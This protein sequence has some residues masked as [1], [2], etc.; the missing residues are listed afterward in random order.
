M[1][2]WPHTND[3]TQMKSMLRDRHRSHRS[4]SLTFHF[5]CCLWFSINGRNPWTTERNTGNTTASV[6]TLG[7]LLLKKGLGKVCS[8]L[9]QVTGGLLLLLDVFLLFFFLDFSLQFLTDGEGLKLWSPDKNPDLSLIISLFKLTNLFRSDKHN[10]K[11]SYKKIY[12]LM[13]WEKTPENSQFL[14]TEMFIKTSYF[15]SRESFW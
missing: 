1:C 11:L 5:I 8:K 14:G 3:I 9:C 6:S 12:I 13:S 2:T 10:L 7:F 15:C 4:F